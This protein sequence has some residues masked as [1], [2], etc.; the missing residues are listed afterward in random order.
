VFLA[1]ALTAGCGSRSSSSTGQLR[2]V[3]AS[4]IPSQVNLLVDGATQAT[5][6]NYSNATGYLTIK[7]GSRH[8]QVLPAGSSTTPV[9]DA[10]ISVTASGNQTLLMTGTS[11][12]IKSHLMTDGNTTAVTGDIHVRV[13]NA[14]NQMGAANVYIF[15]AGSSIVGAT[16]VPNG[17]FG[18][19]QDTGYQAVATGGYQVVMSSPTTGSIFLSTGPINPSS[20]SQNQTV[21]ALDNPAG[22]FTFTVLQDQ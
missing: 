10:N 3:Q 15:L 13:L 14:S 11:G 18:F 19:N 9:L 1:A 8:V 17:P 16:L 6:L 7:S 2:F 21:V 12:S 4:P 5:S 22:G 20:S